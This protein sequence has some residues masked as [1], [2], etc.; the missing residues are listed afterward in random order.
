MRI[1]A[2]NAAPA[3]MV[4]HQSRFEPSNQLAQIGEIGFVERIS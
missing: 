3:Q 1:M 4:R 2:A